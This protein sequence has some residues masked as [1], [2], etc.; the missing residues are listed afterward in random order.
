MQTRDV[1]SDTARLDRA[2]ALRQRSLH[3]GIVQTPQGSNRAPAPLRSHGRLYCLTVRNRAEVEKVACSLRGDR[4]AFPQI[5]VV[6]LFEMAQSCAAAQKA[7]SSS[8]D[9]W[10]Q[11]PPAAGKDDPTNDRNCG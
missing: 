5:D 11:S 7:V 2:A 3:S 8:D 9:D 6:T 4:S 1:D 10:W